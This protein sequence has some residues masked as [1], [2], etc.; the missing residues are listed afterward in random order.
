[1]TPAS[2]NFKRVSILEE[3]IS[4]TPRKSGC[5][6]SQSGIP[7]YGTFS[8]I[9]EAHLHNILA[10]I[11]AP[12]IVWLTHFIARIYANPHSVNEDVSREKPR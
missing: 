4:L 12:D 9:I 2:G 3:W 10:L 1:M 11:L 7:L 6:P 5:R 8:A